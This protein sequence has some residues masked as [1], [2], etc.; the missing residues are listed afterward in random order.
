MPHMHECDR[1]S[2]GM[3]VAIKR[4]IRIIFQAA[5]RVVID[6]GNDVRIGARR[7]VV[8]RAGERLGMGLQ[9]VMR[10]GLWRAEA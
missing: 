4:E 3:A 8:R 5:V 10:E 9:P 6:G 7:R 2:A 1:K